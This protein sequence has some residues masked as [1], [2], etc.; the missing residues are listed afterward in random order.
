LKKYFFLALSKHPAVKVNIFGY[1]VF[2]P[3]SVVFK[4]KKN[5]W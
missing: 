3:W 2:M 1:A 4:K 5:V